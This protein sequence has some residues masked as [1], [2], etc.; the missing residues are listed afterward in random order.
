[1]CV[2]FGVCV[3]VYRCVVCLCVC[4][5][6]CAC[7]CMCVNVHV[8]VRVCVCVRACVCVRGC[9]SNERESMCVRVYVRVRECVG[10]SAP[11]DLY[12]YVSIYTYIIL[13]HSYIYMWG[14]KYA[15]PPQSAY[16]FSQMS[17]TKAGLSRKRTLAISV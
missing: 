15:L 11:A 1:M 17:P 3:C 12:I 14:D 16:L 8:R 4:V 10:V 5:C 7:A 2:F 9:V 13:T 6:V